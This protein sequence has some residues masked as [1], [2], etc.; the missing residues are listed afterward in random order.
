[1]SNY[2]PDV[3]V[4][5]E[6][7]GTDVKERY[8]R[9]LA[10]WYGGYAHGDSWKMSSGVEKIIK[11]GAVYEIHNTSGSIYHCHESVE[12]LSG[13]TGG[14]LRSYMDQNTDKI[15]INQVTLE[16]VLSKYGVEQ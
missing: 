4:I 12:R 9:V 6:L 7:T 13:Y 11:N 5:V 14:V 3:W 10:G 1:M 16:S 2:H 8:H 15:A